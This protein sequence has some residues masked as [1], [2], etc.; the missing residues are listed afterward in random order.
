MT[1]KLKHIHLQGGSLLYVLMLVLIISGLMSAYILVNAYQLTLLDKMYAEEL[2]R[3]NMY[4][5]SNLLLASPLE[6]NESLEKTLFDTGMD[7]ANMYPEAWGVW[8]LVRFKG[9]HGYAQE[10]QWALVGQELSSDRQSALFLDDQKSA[11]VLSGN[12][13][14][15]GTV[16][17]PAAGIKKGTVGIK[18]FERKELVEGQQQSSRGKALGMNHSLL[19]IV[20]DS[21]KSIVEDTASIETYYLRK[22]A[23]DQAWEEESYLIRSQHNLILDEASFRGKCII[24]TTGEILVKANSQLEQ[25]Q[26]YAK[27][28]RFE[29]GFEGSCQAFATEEL[30]VEQ[31][32]HLTYPS[33][34]ALFKATKESVKLRLLNNS[35]LEG[36]L[37]MSEKLLDGEPQR[38]DVMWISPTT[39]IWGLVDV[40]YG[41]S[42]RGKVYG[43]THV[44]QFL[45]RTAGAT[46]KNYLLD[47]E[48]NFDLLHPDFV[49][50][51]LDKDSRSKIVRWL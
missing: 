29:E 32:V 30:V 13:L 26:L 5:G 38:E 45:L 42:L 4:S 48:L 23:V 50:P 19:T 44:G 2:A 47:S 36:A 34:L 24:Q 31:D 27:S 35:T 20:A 39:K 7:T 11:L 21:L 8:G 22:I 17:I 9:I 6:L 33:V 41:L 25:V 1:L 49:S 10:T 16:Y 15:K 28:I 46:Y 51:F 14:L 12:T 37:L 18:G 43:H 3:E 40:S